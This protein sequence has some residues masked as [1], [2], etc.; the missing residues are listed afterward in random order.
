MY[1][2]CSSFSLTHRRNIFVLSILLDF[3]SPNVWVFHLLNNSLTPAGFPE[4][5]AVL[6]L[7]RVGTDPT[8]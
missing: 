5:N 7:T 8:G 4:I 3:W 6:T 2:I 1:L